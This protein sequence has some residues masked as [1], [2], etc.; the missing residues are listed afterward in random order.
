MSTE[1]KKIIILEQDSEADTCRKEVTPKLYVSEWTDDQILEQRVFTAGQIIVLGKVAKRKAPK[2]ADYILRIAQNFAIAVVEAKKR[3]KTAAAGLQQAKNYAEILGLKFAYATNG[4]EIVEFDF[5]T[6]LET[7]IDKYPTPQEL[8]NRLQAAEPVDEYIKE[9][10][11]KPLFPNPDKPPRYYQEIAVNRAVQGILEGRKRLLLTL[12]TGT[13]KTSIAFQIIYKLWNNRW[14]TTGEHRRPKV[15]F[16]ADRTILVDDPYSKD[17]AVFGDA[18]ALVSDSGAK[19]SREIYF[20]TY[21]SLAEDSN[22]QGLFRQFP[23]DF[24]DLIVI[25]ECHRGSASDESNWRAILDYFTTAVQLG[26]TATPL[27]QDNKDTYAY[28]GNPLYVYSLRQGIEDGFL[29]PYI[30]RRIVTE[31]DA[32]GWRPQAGQ[33]DAHGNLIPDGVYNTADFE[34]SL[35]LLPRTKAVARHLTE[36]LRK[37]GRLDKTIVFCVDQDH[38]DQMR[39]EL[40]NLNADLAREH[41][42]Y[43]V[44]IVSEEGDIG[45][46]LLSKFMDI[47]QDF[48]VIVTTSKLLST[49]V[50]IPTCKNVVLF[51][52]V[53]S[54]TEFKQIVGRGTR[55]REDKD[56]L[57]FTILD[58]TG[59]ATRNFA[60]PYFDG[61]PPLIT[62]GE[63]DE[64]G[65]ETKT[66]VIS[67]EEPPADWTD[68]EIRKFSSAV[69]AEGRQK[70]YVKEG[71]VSIVVENVQILDA[72]G[73]LRTVHFTQYAKEQIRTL[74]TDAGGFQKDWADPEQ[75]HRIIAELE[76]RGISLYQLS[77]IT[78]LTDADPFDMLCFVAF[79]L[80]P[81]SRRERA[82]QVKQAAILEGYSEKAKE[83]INLIL[84]KYIQFGVNELNADILEVKP[85]S[86]KGNITEIAALF[87]GAPNLLKAL[88]DIQRLLYA[89][90][91]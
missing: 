60:D 42:N 16:L 29:A 20:S 73:R 52:M 40:S 84:D 51:R 18:R 23:K 1:E 37:F 15:L 45:K 35:S 39:R 13:G 66:E 55:V 86:E 33:T 56:K 22:R 41:P 75:R 79:D 25:D 5:L 21:Q 43:V 9:I 81:M 31:A 64:S 53:N 47:E 4:A 30:V 85:I 44:R 68:E 61:E 17:F 74:Y 24:F 8:W 71:E 87:G 54:M 28:F 38:A 57:F 36:H 46:G 63:M 50:D 76:S 3:Y 19:T 49:G 88:D 91:A 11:L 12:A 32:M 58:Y 80:K 62:V 7:V 6:G 26:L 83:I 69:S 78:R 65:E 82:E 70:Y 90:A 59:S 10:L 72:D 77:D 2:K 34:N 89:E 14:N 27:R 48:P 67:S